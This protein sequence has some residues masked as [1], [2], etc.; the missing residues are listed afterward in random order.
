MCRYQRSLGRW[1]LT[2]ASKE[3]G[4]QRRGRSKE[5]SCA[6][7]GTVTNKRKAHVM[8]HTPPT[9]PRK[10]A[11]NAP[12]RATKA[13]KKKQYKR[14]PTAWNIFANAEKDNV[15]A[16]GFS[17]SDVIKQLALRWK[18]RKMNNGTLPRVLMLMDESHDVDDSASTSAASSKFTTEKS[19]DL[20]LKD[21][22]DA[23]FKSDKEEIKNALLLAK[24]PITDIHFVNVKNLARSLM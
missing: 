12:V 13:I 17:G 23:L 19:S 1:Y 10:T 5:G 14:A 11:P 3:G 8:M 20:S 4:R 6:I 24:L 21:V 2:P 22:E 7:K 15:K 18:A 16:L 9:T